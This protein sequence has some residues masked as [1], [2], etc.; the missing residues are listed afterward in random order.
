M[1]EINIKISVGVYVSE[2]YG[3]YLGR[4]DLFGAYVS[5]ADFVPARRHWAH[6]DSLRNLKCWV[7]VEYKGSFIFS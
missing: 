7:Y 5:S 2:Y 6:G 1:Y 4:T 3:E